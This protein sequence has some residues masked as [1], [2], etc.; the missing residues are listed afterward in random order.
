MCREDKLK[1]LHVHSPSC[2]PGKN[3]YPM[4]AVFLLSQ[5]Q[6]QN[7]LTQHVHSYYHLVRNWHLKYICN[8][9]FYILN[10]S[11]ILACQ[12]KVSLKNEY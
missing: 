2:I 8:A 12:P 1:D 3:Y 6:P 5:T 11:T 9:C 10:E 7:L 4:I